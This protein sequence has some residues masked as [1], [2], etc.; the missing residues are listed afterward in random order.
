MPKLYL[1]LDDLEDRHKGF[2]DLLEG[3]INRIMKAY[4]V[5][6]AKA[7]LDD[8]VFDAAFL[9]FD[10]DLTDPRGNGLDVL[11][12]IIGL[13]PEKRPKEIVVHSH[14]SEAGHKMYV[15]AK[16]AGLQVMYRP[17]RGRRTFAAP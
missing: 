7:H 12:Y 8:Y 6:E 9:D 11:R 5:I 16:Q 13:K 10:L 14:N 17:Y 2:H 15:E 1:V 4:T 3:N